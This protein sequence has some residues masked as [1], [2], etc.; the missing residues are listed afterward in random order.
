[1]MNL[2]IS[3]VSVKEELELPPALHRPAEHQQSPSIPG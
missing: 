2:Q 3:G 1:M